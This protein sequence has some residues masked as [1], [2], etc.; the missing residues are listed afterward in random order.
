MKTK[1]L[2][3]LLQDADPTGEH[4]VRGL[5]GIPKHVELVPGYY[6]GS[7]SY[8][9]EDG[10]YVISKAGCKVDIFCSDIDSYIEDLID[11]HDRYNKAKVLSSFKFENC[12]DSYKEERLKG[13][14]K[15]YD[16]WYNLE[17]EI[18]LEYVEESFNN[19]QLGWTWYQDKKVDIEKGM[20]VYYTW[21]IF[22]ENG[23]QQSSNIKNTEAILYSG[24]FEKLDNS[25]KPGYYQWALKK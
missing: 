3:K 22:D 9:D 21:L 17:N 4:H 20:H 19:A 8:Y 23:K 11:I 10:N 12:S 7:Y 13:I 24:M 15:E 6:D 16:N 14:S 5:G 25:H 18:Y 1:E 2:I